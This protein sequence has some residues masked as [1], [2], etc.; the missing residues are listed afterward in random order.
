MK[1]ARA[2]AWLR[3]ALPVF[4][5]LTGLVALGFLPRRLDPALTAITQWEFRLTDLDAPLEPTEGARQASYLPLELPSYP[6]GE[7]HLLWLRTRLPQTLPPDATLAL[8]AVLGPF[9]AYV[10]AQRVLSYPE[11]LGL[12]AP[13]PVG[14]PWQLIPLPP[15]SGGQ[16]LTLRVR[17]DYRPMGLK[18]TPLLGSR[19]ALLQWALERD[20]PRLVVALV[21]PLLGLLSLM[22]FGDRRSWRLPVSFFGWTVACGV[23]ITHYAHIT[24]LLFPAPLLSFWAWALALPT[25]SLSGVLFLE[26]LFAARPSQPLRW[27]LRVN[28]V[29]FVLYVAALSASAALSRVPGS[30]PSSLVVFAYALNTARL[31]LLASALLALVELTRRALQGD[32]DARLYLTAYVILLALLLRDLLAAFGTAQLA[33]R[34]Q[35]HVGLVVCLIAMALLLQRRHLALHTRAL[36]LEREA[37]DRVHEKVLLLRDLHD[38]IGAHTSNM[39]MLAQIGV[40]KPE[41]A[42]AAL[43]TIAELSSKSLAELRAFVRTQRDEEPGWEQHAAE[44]R[45]LGASL[46]EAHGRRFEM[47]VELRTDERPSPL[48]GL[49]LL[50][51]FNEGLTNAL[52]C[53][54]GSFLRVV[55]QVTPEHLLLRMENDGQRLDGAPRGVGAGRGLENLKARATELGGT[56]GVWLGDTSCLEL[57]VPLTAAAGAA[58]A[59]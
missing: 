42:R 5:A 36:A 11:P 30:A 55:L 45:Q 48:V 38:G 10:G 16:R 28:V 27:A 8:D 12:T 24:D 22:A 46:V 58:S 56:L 13:P 44:L 21:A 47:Q 43:E 18:G 3:Y 29:F 15:G 40:V 19:A 26:A 2:L 6:P 9:E 23:Y 14:L 49:H 34:S 4:L 37:A 35:L 51:I 32:A 20:L 31:V 59:P 50:R 25:A 33:H 52:K 39:M 17:V 57:R 54:T 1:V 41:R 7:G 53:E